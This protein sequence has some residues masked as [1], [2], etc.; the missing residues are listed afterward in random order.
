MQNEWVCAQLISEL[1]LPVAPTDMATFGE[2]TVLVVER[3]DREWMDDGSWIARLPREDFC[4]ALG[5]P[6][7]LKH[8]SDGGPGMAKCLRLLSGSA[9]PHQDTLAF[10][11][12]QLAFWL[13]AAT[14]GH[15]KN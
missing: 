13:V 8:E 2:Q 4:Q 3:F 14:D 10:Q 9:D 7:K 1:G 12:A 6:P 11:L 15:A 5:I